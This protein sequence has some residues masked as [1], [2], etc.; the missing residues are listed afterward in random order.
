MQLGGLYSKNDEEFEI[1]KTIERGT[2]RNKVISGQKSKYEWFRLVQVFKLL[3]FQQLYC[4]L[5]RS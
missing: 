5:N 1:A 2:D 3:N 4:Y